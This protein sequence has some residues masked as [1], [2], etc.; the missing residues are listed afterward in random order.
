MQSALPTRDQI[1][2]ELSAGEDLDVDLSDVTNIDSAGLATL[3]LVHQAARQFGCRVY[4]SGMSDKV[5]KVLRLTHL[6][7][8]FLIEEFGSNQIV[9]S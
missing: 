6:E 8:L 7:G 1:L 3:I 4:L 5:L 9:H 2:S